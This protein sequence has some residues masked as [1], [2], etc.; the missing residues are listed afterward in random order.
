MR[1]FIYRNLNRKGHVYSFK[2]LEGPYK[3]RVV[4]YAQAFKADNVEF[5]VSF[6]GWQRALRERKRNV[7]AGIVGDVTIIDKPINRLPNTLVEGII[8]PSKHA[9]YIRYHPYETHGSF[10]ITGHNR[11]MEKSVTHADSVNVFRNLIRAVNAR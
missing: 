9:S 1:C 8:Y 6:A 11:R 2:A 10:V 3:G 4:A 5:Y 7:H